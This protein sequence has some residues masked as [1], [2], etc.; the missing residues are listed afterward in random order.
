MD[1][2]RIKALAISLYD[3]NDI[4]EAILKNIDELSKKGKSTLSE[5]Q[6][7]SLLKSRMEAKVD[8]MKAIAKSPIYKV[9]FRLTTK[10][11]ETITE[12][13]TLTRDEI[14]TFLN[15][16][17]GNSVELLRLENLRTNEIDYYKI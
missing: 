17:Y 3:S 8:K 4:R 9:T 1:E 12:I 16:L 13:F 15:F 5:E 6:R 2:N 11:V 10:S 7:L 14:D